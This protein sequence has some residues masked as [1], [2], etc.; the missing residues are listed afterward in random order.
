[1]FIIDKKYLIIFTT[2]RGSVSGYKPSPC[3]K[4]TTN[5]DMFSLMEEDMDINCGDIIEGGI[6]LQ[7]MG[8]RDL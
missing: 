8:G 4:L 6:P 2:G 1:M 3:I 5:S 7:V